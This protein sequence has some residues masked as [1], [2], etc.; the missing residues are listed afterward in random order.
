MP[1]FPYTF[2]LDAPCGRYFKYRDFVEC[3]TTWQR[4][5]A[6][7]DPLL[8]NL[9]VPRERATLEG[10][11]ALCERLIDPVCD[12]FGRVQ[13]T[14][15]FASPAF[16]R[17]VRRGIAPALDQ[18][19]GSERLRTGSLVCPRQG[20]AVDLRGASGVVWEI[21]QYVARELPFDRLYYYGPDRPFHV[22]SGPENSR[23][24]TLLRASPSGHI[25]PQRGHPNQLI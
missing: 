12:R 23:Q 16:S 15:G 24:I 2:D 18:H 3:S 1:T 5:A 19:A 17:R 21:A 9:N 11:D 8:P 6:E 7:L 4:L 14:Y 10:I 22:S 13:L 20:Q 25:Y